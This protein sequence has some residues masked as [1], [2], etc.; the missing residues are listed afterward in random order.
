[1][2]T[3]STEREE[4]L[5][6]HLALI[7]DLVAHMRDMVNPVGSTWPTGM[8][9][10]GSAVP[11]APLR[12]DP[13]DDARGLWEELTHFVGLVAE[14]T[15][16]KPPYVGGGTIHHWPEWAI[17][18]VARDL[19]RW[20]DTCIY[21]IAS[22]SFFEGYFTQEVHIVELVR[23][24]RARY[25]VAE[26]KI[27]A[28]RPHPCPTCDEY[29]ILPVFGDDGLEAFECEHCESRWPRDEWQRM[30]RGEASG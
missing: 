4:W 15:G 16:E 3:A 5:T 25:P 13:A 30:R 29:S 14:R 17:A 23:R 21:R 8:P 9:R 11:G 7:P 18:V 19:V 20:V 28:Y 12:L 1:M 6:Y 26:R 24:Y 27:R 22:D 2:S 10:T